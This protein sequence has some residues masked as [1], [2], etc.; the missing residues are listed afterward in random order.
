MS[1][2]KF[3]LTLARMLARWNCER[4]SAP[5]DPPRIRCGDDSNS[6]LDSN[7]R[8]WWQVFSMETLNAK[9]SILCTKQM[10]IYVDINSRYIRLQFLPAINTRGVWVPRSTTESSSDQISLWTSTFPGISENMSGNLTENM[11][12]YYYFGGKSIFMFLKMNV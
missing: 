10:E 6:R 3:S 4:N 1:R 7:E 2:I 11:I 9:I 5:S 8:F 12:R